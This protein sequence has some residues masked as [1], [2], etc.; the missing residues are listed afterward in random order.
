VDST[1]PDGF[2]P[3]LARGGLG[4]NEGEWWGGPVGDESGTSFQSGE[5]PACLNLAQKTRCSI[6]FLVSVRL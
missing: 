6:I 5:T 2:I 4:E 3:D 1:Y